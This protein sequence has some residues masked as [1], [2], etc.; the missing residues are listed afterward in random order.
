MFKRQMF[1]AGGSEAGFLASH[2]QESAPD[3]L[4]FR[5]ASRL[6]AA[7]A[8]SIAAVPAWA[9]MGQPSEWQINLQDAVTPIMEQIHEFNLFIN[10]IIGAIMLFVLV[11]L[12]ICV[13]RFNEK[14][15][16]VPSR[17]THN[18]LLEV[19]WTVVPVLILVIIAIPSFRLLYA[20]YDMPKADLTIKMT[21]L[22][23]YWKVEYQTAQAPVGEA[24]PAPAEAAAPA[25]AAPQGQPAPAPAEQAA[26]PAPEGSAP[27]AATPP[28]AAEDAPLTADF[29][30][31]IRRKE[32]DA[33][34]EGEPYLL[35][36]DNPVVVPVGKVVRVQVT[37]ADVLHAFAVPSFGVKV[38]AVPG[39]L[40]ETWFRADREGIYYGQCSELCGREHAF[41]PLAFRVVSEA[42]YQAWLTQARQQF[43]EN[44][45]PRA[46]ADATATSR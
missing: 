21:G 34:A 41:M 46:F 31:D 26:A 22:Q 11:L 24:A 32:K 43:A 8:F 17:T 27:P 13:L 1:G 9:S 18:T 28:A 35:A 23:W 4:G 45:V 19:V 39:R 20:Q 25:P 30:M 3:M 33:L 36:V 16:P 42:D 10:I 15:N 7:S 12:A 14:R 40:N 37:A 6:L 44:P 29:E 5:L 38:D 2:A